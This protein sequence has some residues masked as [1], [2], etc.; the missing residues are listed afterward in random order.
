M[1]GR[2]RERTNSQRSRLAP[3]EPTP[4]VFAPW[5]AYVDVHTNTERHVFLRFGRQ[6]VTWGDGMLLGADDWSATGRAL[7]AARFGFQAGDL[8]IEL[9]ASILATPGRYSDPGTTTVSEG[10]GVEVYGVDAIYHVVPLVHFEATGLVRVARQPTPVTMTPSDTYVGLARSFGNHRGFRYALE[11]AYKAG[12][13]AEIGALRSLSAF[14]LAGRASFQTSLPWHV[15][16]GS[17]GAYA[18]GD[19]GAYRWQ[20]SSVRSDP[21]GQPHADEPNGALGVVQPP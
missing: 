8:D 19:Q 13:V 10:S 6:A 3:G 1:P 4:P 7:D 9:L 12:S 18:S 20:H 16:L 5:E 11:G 17:Q 2:L 15:T 21:T 14:A